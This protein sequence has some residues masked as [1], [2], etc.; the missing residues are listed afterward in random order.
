TVPHASRYQPGLCGGSSF[1]RTP[2]GG[3][4]ECG[5]D[6]AG[7][8]RQSLPREYHR[9]REPGWPCAAGYAPSPDPYHPRLGHRSGW[10]HVL[11][12]VQSV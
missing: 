7:G 11:R 10:L 6:G 12:A 3:R 1:R 8:P 2:L 5:G 4:A 9:F